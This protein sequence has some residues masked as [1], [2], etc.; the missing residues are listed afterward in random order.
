MQS[1]VGKFRK[2]PLSRFFSS[3][4]FPFWYTPNKFQWFQ[5]VTRGKKK[6]KGPLLIFIPLPF[7]FKFFSFSS[8]FSLFSLPLFSFSSSFSISLPFSSFPPSFQNFPPKLFKGGQLAHLYLRHYLLSS[9]LLL[10]SLPFVLTHSRKSIHSHDSLQHI[11][12]L[13]STYNFT[14]PGYMVWSE[15]FFVKQQL[16][17]SFLSIKLFLLL[18]SA[19]PLWLF[20]WKKLWCFTKKWCY[21]KLSNIIPAVWFI[22][23]VL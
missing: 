8:P 11:M 21:W 5:K 1:K 23:N 13:R 3:Q 17:W 16:F 10:S 2:F 4:K 14:I 18:R 20:L 6:K 12:E 9:L 19:T 22:T 15:V 7:H